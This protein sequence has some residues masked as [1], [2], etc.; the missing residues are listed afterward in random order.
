M[1]GIQHA[2]QGRMDDAVAAFEQAVVVD[3]RNPQAQFA[4]GRARLA[5]GDA[6]GALQAFGEAVRLGMDTADLYYGIGSVHS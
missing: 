3:P 6:S 1:L 5:T 2:E 4:L